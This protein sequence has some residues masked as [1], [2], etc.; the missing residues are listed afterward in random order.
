M[1]LAYIALGSNLADPLQQVRQACQELAGLPESELITCSS[2][3]RSRPMG[4]VEQPDY[5]NAVACIDTRLSPHA[6]L[7][8]LQAIEHAHQRV[9][10]QRWG[11]RTL[12]LDVLLYA[13]EVLR[14]ADL[15]IPH[16]G[17]A[18]RAFVL[19]PLQEIAPDDLMIP[20][21]GLL[22][23]LLCHVTRDGLEVLNDE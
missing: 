19:Y 23:E 11:P 21:L 22:N 1:S 4:P 13:D 10:Q 5:I 7:D 8:E 20:G 17:M 9:R 3:Y 18:Q 6:L 14:D 2:L 12:D 15:T 16:P